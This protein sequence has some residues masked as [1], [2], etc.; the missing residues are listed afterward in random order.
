MSS[1][2]ISRLKWDIINLRKKLA[3]VQSD[4]MFLTD[5]KKLN[6]VPKG[7]IIKNP[8]KS[9]CATSYSMK[10]CMTT[11]IKIRNHILDTLYGKQSYITTQLRKQK[12]ILDQH[13]NLS[14]FE[15]NQISHIA[16]DVYD[17]QLQKLKLTKD[18]KLSVLICNTT[19]RTSGRESD[20]SKSV[21]NH[22]T[23]SPTP[24]E[25]SVLY[26]GLS[27]CPSTNIDQIHLC[28]DLEAFF[29]RLRLKEFFHAHGPAIDNSNRQQVT[30]PNLRT[31][32][33]DAN[34][35]PTEGRN[36]KLDLYINCFRN[37]VRSEIINLKRKCNYN[38]SPLER[39][40]VETHKTNRDIVI[41]PADK[42]GATVIMNTG[43]YIREAN[44]QL[45]N[46]SLYTTLATDP[47]TQ[48]KKELRS[49]IKDFPKD[50]KRYIECTTHL[51]P[52]PGTFYLLPK[53][54]KQDNPGRPIISGIGTL[55]EGISKYVDRIL[56]PFATSANSYIKDTTDFLCK[57]QD[58]EN[59]PQGTLLATMDVEALYSNIPH[60]DGLQAISDTVTD[61][62]ELICKLTNFILSHNYF[63]FDSD[64][65]LQING[66]AM[67]TPMAPQYA[68]IF[69]SNLEQRFLET[70]T[71]RPLL[72]LR[73]IDDIFMIWT[74]GMDT[75]LQFHNDFHNFH[76]TI[77]L[78]LE[79]SDDKVN[80][81]DTTIIIRNQKLQTSLYRKPTDNQCYLHASSFHPPHILRSII[82]SQSL[83]Y[84]RICSDQTDR[85]TH[86]LELSNTFS[87]LK[88]NPN[89]IHEQVERAK[90]I[91]RKNLLKC[92]PKPVKNRT[93][94]VVTYNPMLKPLKRIIN[95]LQPIISTD[96]YLAD[97]FT[98]KVL[99][100]TDNHPISDNN[101]FTANSLLIIHP[102]LFLAIVT[103][104]YFAP[105]STL[106]TK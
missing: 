23:Y 7:L 81:L 42:G 68:N 36:P 40:A 89:T 79:Y 21:V 65:Y 85:D 27:F 47:T 75:L 32:R 52:K 29:R 48:C 61:N 58:I 70:Q 34:W 94:L 71:L 50:I 18:K 6:V 91:D 9:T 60:E 59:L 97:V 76:P 49:L 26:R 95:D 90:R 87:R 51:E 14:V 103:N 86:L 8:L 30:N 54:H 105:I 63:L 22:S 2:T 13:P 46:S 88:Y 19:A 80:F 62:T 72:Y 55:T 37:R 38:L 25:L 102:E 4:I 66:T 77:N 67:G 35:T 53:I 1:T 73:Y 28:G 104:A 93:P 17:K 11:S 33:N 100:H 24:A 92:T 10:I 99:L 101:S 15:R 3:Q 69:M 96:P 74:H 78:T 12:C 43:D 39:K 84:N 31:K 82:F 106:T 98:D 5:C 83:R 45:S 41:K 57:L 56:R 20:S 16:M 44:R 64:M